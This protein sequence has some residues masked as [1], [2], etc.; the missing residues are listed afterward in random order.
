MKPW[1]RIT[2]AILE[3]T[4]VLAAVYFEPN[5]CVRGVLAGEAFF[6]GRPT[7][8]WRIRCDE[9]LARFTDDDSLTQF[10]WLLPFELEG[11]PGL[12]GPG[13]PDDLHLKGGSITQPRET[14]RQRILNAFRTKRDLDRE[15]EYHWS[16]EILWA[17]PD[18][19]QVLKEL[20]NE[21]KYRWLAT[22]GLRRIDYYRRLEAAAAREKAGAK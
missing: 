18:T 19:E 20:Q 15:K 4:I 16:P 7:S 13:I 17:T 8:Y 11:K 1:F 5:C 14:M 2:V 22:L 9:W 3:A 6:A 12:Y 10:T 21:E